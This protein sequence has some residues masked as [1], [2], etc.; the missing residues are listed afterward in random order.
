MKDIPFY[1]NDFGESCGLTVKSEGDSYSLFY[2][3]CKPFTMTEQQFKIACNP[4]EQ[5]DVKD[6]DLKA[7][8]NK[9]SAPFLAAMVCNDQLMVVTFMFAYRLYDNKTVTMI[10]AGDNE[11]IDLTRKGWE[12]FANYDEV[13]DGIID[14]FFQI[15][16]N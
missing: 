13:N 4:L 8:L 10:F 15:I 11:Y 5:V 6:I 7:G 16:G 9:I 1:G 3:G 2:P 12:S 14:V